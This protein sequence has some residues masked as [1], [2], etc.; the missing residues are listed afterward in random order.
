MSIGPGNVHFTYAQLMS[1]WEQAQGNPQAA[2]IAAAIATAESGGNSAAYNINT[3]KSTDRGL[4]QINSVHGNQSTFDVMGNARAAVAISNNGRNWSPWTTY[5]N[6]AYRRYLQINASPDNN[7]PINATNAVGNQPV[8]ATPQSDATLLSKNCWNPLNWFSCATGA[9]GGAV[10]G[11]AESVAQD[12]FGAI[13]TYLINPVI[14]IMAGVI[15]M[16]GGTT[17]MIIG[18]FQIVRSSE[19]YDS[20]KEQK[21][22]VQGTALV[23]AG[24]ATGQPELIAAG[25]SS[26]HK[27][28]AA[29]GR[30]R[31]TTQRGQQLEERQSRLISQ[32]QRSGPTATA[33]ERTRKE[34]VK[35]EALNYRAELRARNKQP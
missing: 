10:A 32:R 4:W 3:N 20:Y 12:I 28:A 22:K 35:Q 2:S 7:V 14:E 31:M 5:T 11:G 13:I 19:A 6:G 16:T 33:A 29:A 24:A 23:V 17:L 21:D 15:G 8:A 18:I 1:I 26:A 25:A 30:Q 34:Q 27:P 9:V